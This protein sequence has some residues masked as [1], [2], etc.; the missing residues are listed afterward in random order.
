MTAK[1]RQK[2][3]VVLQKKKPA[4]NNGGKQRQSQRVGFFKLPDYFSSSLNPKLLL[5]RILFVGSVIT[6]IIFGLIMVYSASFVMGI[7]S[8]DQDPSG[9]LFK[10]CIS[11]GIGC[12]FLAVVLHFDYHAYSGLPVFVL[13][14]LSF[15][16][17]I[18]VLLLG[19]ASHGAV[20][21]FSIG[22]LT[23]QPSEFVKAVVV[24]ALAV[25]CYQYIVLKTLDKTQF[26]LMVGVVCLG[27]TLLIFAQPDKGTALTLGFTIFLGLLASGLPKK[28]IVAVFLIL[29][30]G[31]LCVSFGSSYSRERFVTMLNPESD[32]YG[33]GYQ[34]MQGKYAFGSGGI[35]GVGLGMGKQKYA[36][37]PEMHNDF[38]FAV[39]G[40]EL[41]FLGCLFVLVLFLVLLWSGIQIAKQAP[42]LLGKLIA[43]CAVMLL[44][45]SL[46]LNVLGVLGLFPLSG[47]AIPFISY[48]GSSMMGSL[49]LVGLVIQVSKHG[50]M[51]QAK[52][53]K[54]QP[55]LKTYAGGRTKR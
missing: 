41:G 26:L 38:I 2:R 36:Y 46:L 47:K 8:D 30:I 42:D 22:P 16:L 43:Y 10:Q 35:F 11:I 19:L 27:L 18:G 44:F 12:I 25:F 45:V 52:R 37:L 23:I 32:P 4:Q 40:E 1:K 7:T 13:A 50:V 24:I 39:I 33:S 48:G 49:I 53:R 31:F 34:L 28:P 29:L 51:P 15:F 9:Y 17:L 55:Q 14:G 21:W 6:L 3:R 54:K 5:P 20:R